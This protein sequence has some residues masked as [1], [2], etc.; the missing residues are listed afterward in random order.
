MVAETGG[1]GLDGGS[2]DDGSVDDGS[3][4]DGGVIRWVAGWVVRPVSVW[5]RP[6]WK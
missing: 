4:D 3:G 2:V 6:R 5:E 1:E